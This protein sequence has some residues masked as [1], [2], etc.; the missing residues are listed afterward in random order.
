MVDSQYPKMMWNHF[1][2]QFERTNNKV[3][4]DNNKMKLFCGAANPCIDKAIGLLQTYE[5]ISAD[6]YFNA[7]KSCAKPPYQRPDQLAR[8]ANLKQIKE[9]LNDGHITC[10]TNET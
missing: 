9:M 5:A 10:V 7:K 2:T 4:G 1:D 8:D 3:E 6:K